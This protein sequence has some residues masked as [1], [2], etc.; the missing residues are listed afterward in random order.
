MNHRTLGN[1]NLEVSVTGAPY[2]AH[3]EALTGR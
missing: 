3:L 1:G 2:P